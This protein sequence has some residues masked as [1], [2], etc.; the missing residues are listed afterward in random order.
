MEKSRRSFSQDYACFFQNVG[1]LFFYSGRMALPFVPEVK[2]SAHSSISHFG[3]EVAPQ[4]PTDL[5][6]ANHWGAISE[7]VSMR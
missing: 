1:L 2:V 3:V 6:P 4:M 5:H 7:A